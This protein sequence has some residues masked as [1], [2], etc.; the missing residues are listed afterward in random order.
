MGD[1]ETP[2]DADGVPLC[3]WC[4]GQ[5]RQPGVGRQ[6]R[7]CRQSCRQRAYE[8]RRVAARVEAEA[9][10]RVQGVNQYWVA[11]MAG[12]DSSRDT[13]DDSSRDGGQSSRD[14]VE[15]SSRDRPPRQWAGPRAPASGWSQPRRR[16]RGGV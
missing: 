14:E 4:G 13:T 9:Q 15:D 10:Q 11:R 12:V 16:K 2:R 6:R 8:E 3:E 1:Q 5:V 7:Y